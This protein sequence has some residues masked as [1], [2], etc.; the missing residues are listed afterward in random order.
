[1]SDSYFKSSDQ[2]LVVEHDVSV[3]RWDNARRYIYVFDFEFRTMTAITDFNTSRE[4][5]EVH[6]F[7][8]VDAGLLSRMRDKLVELGGDPMPLSDQKKKLPAPA[9]PRKEEG[10]KP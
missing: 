6:P 3:R 5:M 9:P 2:V 4:R 7:P 8:G 10:A 1:M